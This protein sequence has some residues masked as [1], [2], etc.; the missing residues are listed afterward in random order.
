MKYN[1]QIEMNPYSQSTDFHQMNQEHA[2]DI[3]NNIFNE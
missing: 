2:V 1:R 3:K